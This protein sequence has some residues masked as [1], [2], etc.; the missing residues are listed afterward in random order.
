MK[1][2]EDFKILGKWSVIIR[3]VI[4]GWIE[5]YVFDV[6]MLCIGYYVD[7]NVLDFFGILEYILKL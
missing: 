3:D 6:V 1:K 7:K 2:S 4:I 5:D